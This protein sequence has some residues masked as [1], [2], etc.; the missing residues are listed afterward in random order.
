MTRIDN[1]KIPPDDTDSAFGTLRIVPEAYPKLQ[2]EW[3]GAFRTECVFSHARFDDP[4]VYPGRP[5][6]AHL[7]AFYGNEDMNAYSTTTDNGARSTCA[8]GIGNRSSYWVPTIVDTRDDRPIVSDYLQIYYKTGYYAVPPESVV[9]PP[10]GLRMIAGQSMGATSP[11][12]SGR[13]YWYC[14]SVG[15]NHQTIPSCGSGD[16]LVMA[17]RMP[18]CWNGRDLDSADHRSHMAYPTAGQ[19]CPST[20]PVAIPE[21]AQFAWYPVPATGTTTWRLS[22]DLAAGPAGYSAHADWWNGWDPGVID[23][24]R[25]NCWNVKMDCRMNLLGDGTML[26]YPTP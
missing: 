24:I 3:V 16:T 23:K 20:H 15:G 4:I 26:R 13:T 1:A 22:S 6:A 21:I 25:R 17:V 7:H 5:G 19:G 8:G 9:V 11:D 18:Q 10:P 12:S 14:K 2:D